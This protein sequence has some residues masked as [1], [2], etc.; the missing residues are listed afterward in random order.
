MKTKKYITPLITIAVIGLLICYF[1]N[2]SKLNGSTL[3]S[4]ELRLKEI[5]NLG[6]STNIDQEITIDGYIISGYTTDNNRYGLAVFVPAGN[7]KYDFQTNINGQKDELIFLDYT[8]NT[9][10]YTLVWANKADLDYAEITYTTEGKTGETI[11]LDAKNNKIIYTEA[12]SNDFSVK[13]RFIDEN[14]KIYE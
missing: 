4:R 13:Y 12:P 11:R 1:I 14:G 6:E 2:Q 10:L 9:K 8:I 3:E 5:S 7:G